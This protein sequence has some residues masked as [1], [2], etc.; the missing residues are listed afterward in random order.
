MPKSAGRSSS[1]IPRQPGT[2]PARARH[3]GGQLAPQTTL[4]NAASPTAAARHHARAPQTVSGTDAAPENSTTAPSWGPPVYLGEILTDEAGRLLVLGGHGVSA[5]SDGSR[6]ITFANNEGWHDDVSDGPVTAE[7]K[8]N[9]AT[10]EVVPAWVV[11]APPNY[12]PQRKSVRTMWDLMR[13]VAIKAGTLAAPARPS[14]THDIL[15]IFQ[16]LAG[17][18]VGQCRLRRRVRLGG[19]VRFHRRRQPREARRPQPRRAASSGISSPTVPPISTSI[20]GRRRPGLGYT[21]TR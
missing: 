7:V 1:P 4:R 14:F 16:R 13:D 21:A 17:S 12:G 2:V 10:L 11:V 19:R 15:P 3:P 6:A 20:P 9:G 18:A 5:S 8:L